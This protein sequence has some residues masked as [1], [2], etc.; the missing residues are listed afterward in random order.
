MRKTI[1]SV[2]LAFLIVPFAFSV[3]LEFSFFSGTG[4]SFG[5]SHGSGNL[6]FGYG[7]LYDGHDAEGH[8][9]VDSSSSSNSLSSLNNQKF[10]ESVNRVGTYIQLDRSFLPI[11]IGDLKM[12]LNFG[13]QLIAPVY[14]SLWSD[15]PSA[16]IS[17]SICFQAALRDFE[18]K[19]GW[20]GIWDIFEEF[21]D[22]KIDNSG[23]IKAEF[24]DG[25]WKNCFTFGI[26]Y[27]FGSRTPKAQSKS[28]SDESSTY[29]PGTTRILTGN[30]RR[31]R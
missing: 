16:N 2:L 24:D 4:V 12:G 28:S 20:K 22:K 6:H 1:L 25:A 7:V 3:G 10:T 5:L 18:I 19:L 14:S 23:Y 13:I 30:I 9:K 8:Y 17:P 26:K 15:N 27:Y 11:S 31:T 29:A 21:D